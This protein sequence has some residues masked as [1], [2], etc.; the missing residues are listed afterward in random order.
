MPDLSIQI[1]L[2]TS[3]LQFKLFTQIYHIIIHLLL[4]YY[5]KYNFFTPAIIKLAQSNCL[6]FFFYNETK[7]V[8]QVINKGLENVSGFKRYQ[9]LKINTCRP[10]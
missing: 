9:K 7:T 5:N 10:K 6:Y 1:L 4:I 8:I 3:I 2:K